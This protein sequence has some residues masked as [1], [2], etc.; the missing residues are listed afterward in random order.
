M[1]FHGTVPITFATTTEALRCLLNR[2][3]WLSLW[4]Y[5]IKSVPAVSSVDLLSGL[6][7]SWRTADY[8]SERDRERGQGEGR[9]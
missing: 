6:A 1:F 8:L 9:R 5:S 7:N 4:T 3:L 2:G